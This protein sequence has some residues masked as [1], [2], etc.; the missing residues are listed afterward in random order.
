MRGGA[1]TQCSP[2]TSFKKV[3]QQEAFPKAFKEKFPRQVQKAFPKAF[4]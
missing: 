1:R 2:S 4:K 3:P